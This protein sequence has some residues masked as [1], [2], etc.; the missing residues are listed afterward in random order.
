M[1]LIDAFSSR[2]PVSISLNRYNA[3]NAGGGGVLPDHHTAAT[4]LV[5][6]KFRLPSRAGC[7][8]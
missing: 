1:I 7:S 6:A 3:R 8:I 4:N 2:E 5:S